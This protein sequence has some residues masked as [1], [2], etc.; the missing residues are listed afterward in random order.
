MLLNQAGQLISGTMSNV[1]LVRANTL[2]T[3]ALSASGVAGIMRR[4]ILEYCEKSQSLPFEICEL[5][6]R[7]AE[8]AEELFVCNSNIGI[9]PA[10]ALGKHR[11]E[12][13]PVTLQVMAALRALGVAECSA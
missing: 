3:P 4:L 9:W 5:Q 10:A 12:T 13:G 6:L 11:F 1:F 8:E 7:D 2:C